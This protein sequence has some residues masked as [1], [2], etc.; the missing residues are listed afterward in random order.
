M[1]IIYIHQ[2]FKT[3]YEPGGTRSYWISRSLIQAGHK[4]TVITQN[5]DARK[6][7]EHTAIDGIDIIYIKNKYSNDMSI[8]ERLLSFFL[9]MIKST[10]QVVKQ[11]NVDLVISTST[12]LSVGFP[13]LIMKG[14]RNTPF[15][16]EVRDLWPEVPIQ[17][18]GLQNPILRWMAKSFE[19]LIYRQAK[20]IVTLS[21]GMFNGV[22]NHV[23]MN[24][25]SM[26]PNMAKN[27]KFWPRPTSTELVKKLNLSE[28]S[29]KVIY[30]GAMGIANGLQYIMHA[31]TIINDQTDGLLVEFIF[32]GEGKEKKRCIDYARKN[33]LTNVHF[34][35][36][37]AMDTTSEIVNLSDVSI[38][39]FLNLPI[40]ATNSPNKLF[41]SLSAAKPVIVI[42][43]GWTRKMVEDFHCGAYVDP[44][45]PDVLANMIIEWRNNPDLLKK[46]GRNSR[47]LAEKKYDKSI[48]TKQF[49]EIIERHFKLK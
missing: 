41:D 2:Y 9:F 21:P 18:G 13:A 36:R 34:F 40:L 47:R 42:S 1:R 14:V 6:K 17:M 35:D 39:S 15:L 3:P 26:I 22:I 43:N 37:V 8:P 24:K 10:A 48:L 4:V 28:Q 32:L 23:K 5:I 11:K 33:Q 16:F 46:M 12:P 38:I 30:F 49:I 7:V 29:F 19:Q 45:K 25:V 44:E 20:H 31:A 27:D